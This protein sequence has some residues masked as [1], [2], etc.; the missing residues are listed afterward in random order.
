MNTRRITTIEE[1]QI[2]KIYFLAHP[3][4]Y[5]WKFLVRIIEAYDSV[6]MGD[7]SWRKIECLHIINQ[8][9]AED[10]Y[11]NE[12]WTIRD[13]DYTIYEYGDITTNPEYFL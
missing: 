5:A 10:S 2:G 13:C 8:G 4:S 3:Y 6:K 7:D 1:L 11:I 9:A 12:T